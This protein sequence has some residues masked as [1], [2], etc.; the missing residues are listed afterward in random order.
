MSKN[1]EASLKDVQHPDHSSEMPRL[2]RIIGQ[3]EGIERMIQE[4]RYCPDIIQQL[5]AAQSAIK[6]LEL[7]ILKTH[8]TSC[9]RT[10]A[11]NEKNSA[12]DEKLKEF[13]DLIKN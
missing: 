13:L 11:K 8:L 6:A 12:F 4:R 2:N 7:Q 9:I 1:K 10:A 3:M 5:R